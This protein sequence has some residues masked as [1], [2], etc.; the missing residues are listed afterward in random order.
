VPL[1]CTGEGEEGRLRRIV[2]AE[3]EVCVW[4]LRKVYPFLTPL[5]LYDQS[6]CQGG[7]GCSILSDI[8]Q[9]LHALGLGAECRVFL[10]KALV[11]RMGMRHNLL[12]TTSIHFG[13]GLPF[14][15]GETE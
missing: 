10:R 5:R 11:Q 7:E 9:V 14:L 1:V 2:C 6:V 13:V 4:G 3:L 15:S 12:L 8:A